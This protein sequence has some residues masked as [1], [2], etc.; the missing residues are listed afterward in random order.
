MKILLIKKSD[1]TGGASI[2]CVRLLN[3]LTSISIDAKLLVQ[4][5]KTSNKQIYTTADTRFKRYINFYRFAYER[6]VFSFYERSKDV[7]FAFSLANTGEDI[8]K[9]QILKEADVI[10][11]HWFNMGFLSLDDLKCLIKLR[12]PIVWTLHDMWAFTGGCHYVGECEM[13]KTKCKNC[14][15]L[16][17]PAE[18]D[19]SAKIWKKKLELFSEARLTFVTCSNWLADIARQST[20][21]KNFRIESIPNPIDTELFKPMERNLIRKKLQLPENKKIILFGAANI[22]DKR[23][24]FNFLFNALEILSEKYENIAQKVEL[25]IFGREKQAITDNLP[26]RVHKFNYLASQQAVAELYN[27]ADCF[28]LPSL[29][30]NLPNTVMESLACGT[31]VVAFNTGGVPQMIDHKINGFIAQYKSADD[32][33]EGIYSTLFDNANVDF[34][35][36]ARNKVLQNF[37]FEIVANKYLMLYKELL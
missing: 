29:E 1:S 7:R 12:K 15:F 30:D 4:E 23:K 32:L 20:L 10:H 17:N 19:L 2:A 11:L 25:L 14:V 18:N 9:I 16:K 31:P 24:G 33:A 37:T 8:S 36:N 22:S 6:F 3:A 28:V 34:R 35:N 13:F 27:A 5:K 21:L 26:F